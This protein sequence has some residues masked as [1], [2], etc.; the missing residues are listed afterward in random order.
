MPVIQ[1]DR[2]FL[3]DTYSIKYESLEPVDEGPNSYNFNKTPLNPSAAYV[4]LYDV[5]NGVFIPLNPPNNEAIATVVDN[6]ISYTIAASFFP[7]SGDYKV[8][9]RVVY[10]DG[11][12]ATEMRKVK[13]IEKA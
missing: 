12:A 9:T 2:I 13:V 4:S 10:P 1:A 5:Q 7:A 8:F 6:I 11:R 3:G